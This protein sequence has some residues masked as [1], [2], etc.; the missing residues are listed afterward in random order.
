LLQA[1]KLD[2]ML[3]AVVASAQGASEA[4]AAVLYFS[5]WLLYH[6]LRL[7]I[8]Y[9]LSGFELEL[10]SVHEFGY[11]YWYLYELLFPWL[12]TCLH[13]ADSH[14]MEYEQYVESQNKSQGTYLIL[15]CSGTKVRAGAPKQSSHITIPNCFQFQE[16]EKRE[17]RQKMLIKTRNQDHMSKKLHIAKVIQH[18]VLVILRYYKIQCIIHTF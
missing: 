9:I 16:E 15:D 13:R 10:F 12:T 1:D 3:N 2:T 18:S 6:V 8:R 5:T 4:P 11:L 7:M 14:L 17:K